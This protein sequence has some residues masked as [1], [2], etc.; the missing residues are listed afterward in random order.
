MIVLA[1]VVGIG[2]A[3]AYFSGWLDRQENPNQRIE[4]SIGEAGE[5]EVVLKQNRYGHYVA[6]GKIN[7]EPV[8]FLLDTGAT[9]ISVPAGV[10]EKAGLEAGAPARARTAAGVISTYTTRI[11]KVELGGIVLRDVRAGINPHMRG[12]D[13]L[14]GMSFLRQLDFSQ[15]GDEL[16]LRQRAGDAGV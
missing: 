15:R 16:T 7:G 12:D 6:S 3:T 1:W 10:A 9:D 8:K 14:L 2:I 4:T 13:V 11:D 5:R